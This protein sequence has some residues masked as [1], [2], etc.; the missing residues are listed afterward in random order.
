M[1][2]LQGPKRAHLLSTKHT[3]IKE[4]PGCQLP[5]GVMLSLKGPK[6]AHLL[7]TKQTGIKEEPGCQPPHGAMWFLGTEKG[8]PPRAQNRQVQKKGQEAGRPMV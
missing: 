1:L 2:S 8:P 7:S 6:R 5:H 4:E 3:G